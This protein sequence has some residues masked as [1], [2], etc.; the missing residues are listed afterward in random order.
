MRVELVLGLVRTETPSH[1]VDRVDA[2]RASEGDATDETVNR[3][4]AARNAVKT[5]PKDESRWGWSVS[6]RNWEFLRGGLGES[7]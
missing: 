7:A 1:L 2:P 3:R 5:R 4:I 6:L